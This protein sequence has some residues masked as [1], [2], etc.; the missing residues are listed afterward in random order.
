[1]LR[2]L[3]LEFSKFR[4]STVIVLLASFYFLF[5]PFSMYV[6]TTLPEIPGLAT[7]NTLVSFTK[8]WEYAGY[9]GNWMVFFFFGVLM[10]Y[11][12][13][14][15]VRFKTM[16]QSIIIGLSRKEFFISK[17]LIILA[18]ALIASLYYALVTFIIGW[19]NT[20]EPDLALAFTNEW[21]IPRYFL[22]CV[23][24][25]SFA[26]MFAYIFRNAGVAIFIYL[27]Y[28]M[29]GENLIR[30][31]HLKFQE[32]GLTNYYPMNATEDLMPLPLFKLAEYIQKK[33]FDFDLLLSY[34]TAA[35]MTSIYICIFIAISYYNFMK[36]DV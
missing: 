6:A 4:K 18:L 19:L 17:L 20:S 27:S 22:M 32:S 34:G 10:I 9:A 29:I 36:K 13:S 33:E 28:V 26:M 3:K 8:V 25:M 11:T 31:A 35:T 5:L 23:S 16:R 24:Y 30:L 2:L 14:L 21:A 7:K 15:E 12:I 1:M